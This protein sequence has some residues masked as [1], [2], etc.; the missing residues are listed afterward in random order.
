MIYFWPQL[1]AR[2]SRKHSAYTSSATQDETSPYGTNSR[3]IR[4]RAD[5]IAP[6]ARSYGT[7]TTIGTRRTSQLGYIYPGTGMEEMREVYGEK[8]SVDLTYSRAGSPTYPTYPPT[9][10][11]SRSKSPSPTAVSRAGSPT[12]NSRSPTPTQ[13]QQHQHRSGSPAGSSHLHSHSRSPSPTHIHH[14]Q[15]PRAASPASSATFTNPQSGSATPIHPEQVH[16]RT[17]SPTGSAT[18]SHSHSRSPSPTHPQHQQSPIRAPSPAWSASSSQS[19]SSS[20]PG[21]D[22]T[23][24]TH[25]TSPAWSAASSSESST[26]STNTSSS[27]S[28]RRPPN[29][30]P[31]PPNPNQTHP[32]YNI[33]PRFDY[34]TLMQM[35][36]SGSVSGVDSPVESGASSPV[37][38]TWALGSPTVGGMAGL[39]ITGVP[40]GHAGHHPEMPLEHR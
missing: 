6:V 36:G 9:T 34:E 5:S 31:T 29:R 10:A 14:H 27:S 26:F 35:R 16:P 28:S 4:P 18:S 12:F 8:K 22:P 33:Y 40:T 25:T 24:T 17:A 2:A 15:N 38:G 1:M 39:G 37:V 7:G 20:I 11:S 32:L 3:M 13:P 19:S 21:A 30:T 23:L